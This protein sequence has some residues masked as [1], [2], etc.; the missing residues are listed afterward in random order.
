M[1]DRSICRS[2]NDHNHLNSTSVAFLP[3]IR[4][5]ATCSLSVRKQNSSQSLWFLHPRRKRASF[6]TVSIVPLGSRPFHHPED[7]LAPF[8]QHH[9][10]LAL[11]QRRVLCPAL[12]LPTSESCQNMGGL[13]CPDLGNI[14]NPFFSSKADANNVEHIHQE[15]NSQHREKLVWI[16]C[17]KVVKRAFKSLELWTPIPLLS[18]FGPLQSGLKSVESFCCRCIITSTFCL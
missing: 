6:L 10:I 7:Q 11:I 5:E 16:T 2:V 8:V 12:L 18:C 14:Q 4:A 15:G 13:L 9:K 3:E 1:I 17:F